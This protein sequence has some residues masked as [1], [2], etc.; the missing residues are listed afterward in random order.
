[1]IA[2]MDM[3]GETRPRRRHAEGLAAPLYTA[4]LCVLW[5]LLELFCKGSLRPTWINAW[6]TV[7]GTAF[8]GVLLSPIATGLLLIGLPRVES[9]FE[10]RANWTRPIFLSCVLFAYAAL[11]YWIARFTA[12]RVGVRLPRFVF[13]AGLAFVGVCGVIVAMSAARRP[14]VRVRRHLVPAMFVAYWFHIQSSYNGGTIHLLSGM[15]TYGLLFATVIVTLCRRAPV[16]LRRLLA[17]IGVAAAL[18]IIP[19]VLFPWHWKTAVSVRHV[20]VDGSYVGRNAARVARFALPRDALQD[21]VG[22]E[23]SATTSELGPFL[24]EGRELVRA[25][26]T[27]RAK[28]VLLIT[29]DT[30][31]RD[32]TQEDDL[33]AFRRLRDE[34]VVFENARSAAPLTRM[35]L[36]AMLLGAHRP[37]GGPTFA[38]VLR[39]VGFHTVQVTTWSELAR[40][41]IISRG[42]DS[43]ER[44]T[45]PLFLA[46]SAGGQVTDA[47]LARLAEV[48]APFFAWVH[49]LE[50]HAPY[51]APGWSDHAR[52]RGEV[53]KVD[54]EL[55]RLL[56]A[57]AADGRLDETL[58][59]LTADHGEEFGEH[60]GRW[61]GYSLYDEVVRVPLIIRAP[62][63]KVHGNVRAPVSGV[64]L[65]PTLLGALGLARPEGYAP[66]GLDVAT[67]S[68]ERAQVIRMGNGQI[69]AVVGRWKLLVHPEYGSAELYDIAADPGE[70]E[71]LVDAR[72]DVSAALGP[73]LAP[74][75]G[76]GSP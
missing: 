50:P 52:Y 45:L 30:L 68:P 16:P 59:V 14:G 19:G 75:V 49:Y 23:R 28:N 60:G 67:A 73:M 48:R 43:I 15:L 10:R 55:G 31:R 5:A 3:V 8:A 58:V 12:L 13:L 57:L 40:D 34:G 44:S 51:D 37:S 69:A 76:G 4:L 71:N 65:G 61:H 54:A 11:A 66:D 29:V 46:P 72:P 1:M 33:P 27:V 64:D 42:F 7:S 22:K 17:E 41:P 70:H 24:D 47:T 2:L 26:A 63:G 32:A 74:I 36:Q 9:F 21:L 38:E 53:A 62:G 18:L 56:D 25:L 35:S 20:V 39:Q 6:Y